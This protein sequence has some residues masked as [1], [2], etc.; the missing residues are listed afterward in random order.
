MLSRWEALTPPGRY[1]NISQVS[2]QQTL[3]LIYQSRKDRKLSEIRW[4]GSQ[5]NVKNSAEPGIEV[6]IM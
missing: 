4:K 2:S 6:R 1:T 5:T 3:V